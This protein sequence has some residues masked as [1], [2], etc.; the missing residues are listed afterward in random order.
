VFWL[1]DHAKSTLRATDVCAAKHL[2]EGRPGGD[3]YQRLNLEA[4]DRGVEVERIFIYTEW[5]GEIDERI[6]KQAVAGVHT[7]RVHEA[8]LRSELRSD[9]AIWDESYGS[10]LSFNASGE[11]VDSYVTFSPQDVGR[12]LERYNRIRTKAEIWPVGG[13]PPPSG[14]FRRRP[15]AHS[16]EDSPPT[17]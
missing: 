3:E 1:T 17:D 2:H 12:L 8:A 14:K 15:K 16:S 13:N 4:V 11:I 9:M 6:R 5:T 7:L 10:E